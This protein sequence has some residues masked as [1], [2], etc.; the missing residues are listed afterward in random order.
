MSIE[1]FH[2][3]SFPELI[4]RYHDDG[5]VFVGPFDSQWYWIMSVDDKDCIVRRLA[6]KGS[7]RIQFS[8][9]EDVL[10]TVKTKDGTVDYNEVFDNSVPV[11]KRSVYLQAPE[12]GLSHDRKIVF[13][14]S[15]PSKAFENLGLLLQNLRVDRSRGEPKLFSQLL[16]HVL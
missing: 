13:D 8:E 9:F 15:N 4:R 10:N 16:S 3:T 7:T 12:L 1:S 2:L 6:G 14:L 11:I 5:S